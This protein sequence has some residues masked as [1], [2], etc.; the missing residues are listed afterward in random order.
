MSLLFSATSHRVNVGSGAT[1]D[2]V[3]AGTLIFLAFPT[4]TTTDG[5]LY[6]KGLFG[7]GNSL[8]VSYGSGAANLS[9]FRDRPSVGLAATALLAD[10]ANF[11]VNTWLWFA[12]VWDTAGA[13]GDQ[14]LY[15][16]SLSA[17][18]A[19]PSAYSARNAGSGTPGDNSAVDGFLGNNSNLN[20]G[21]PGRIA[22]AIHYNVPLTLGQLLAIQFGFARFPGLIGHWE[23]GYN[24]VGLQP[25]LSGNFNAGTVTGATVAQHAPVRSAFGARGGRQSF[26][27]AAGGGGRLVVSHPRFDDLTF[28]VHKRK[29][30]LGLRP[31]VAFAQTPIGQAAAA[32]G[33]VKPHAITMSRVQ[34]ARIIAKGRES[35][36]SLLGDIPVGAII[37]PPVPGGS[38]VYDLILRRR[39]VRR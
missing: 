25:D 22:R 2:N 17:P 28:D 26:I 24:G 34:L 32:A 33:R 20:V 38:G 8:G 11:A 3:N 4:S 14:R 1:L 35:Q 10:F 19:E 13:A 5:R 16:G 6:Q 15:I 39:I 27:A 21:F 7:A 31:G 23:L 30:I 29:R 36:L 37:V 18:F 12:F 9:V